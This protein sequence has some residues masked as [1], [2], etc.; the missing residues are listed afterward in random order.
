M[1][2]RAIKKR[3]KLIMLFFLVG[4]LVLLVRLAWIQF[5]RGEEYSRMAAEQQ[6]RDSVISAKRG[7]IYDRNL[8]ILAQSASAERVTLNPQEIEKSKNEEEVVSALVKILGVDE[9]NLRKQISRTNRQSVV[10]GGVRCQR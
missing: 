1:P 3:M 4:V 10:V 5:V 8:K 2:T 6:T 9:A 7:S